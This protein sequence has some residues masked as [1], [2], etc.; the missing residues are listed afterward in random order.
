MLF[1]RVFDPTI[2]TG[3]EISSLIALIYDQQW[4]H[5]F[6]STDISYVSEVRDINNDIILTKNKLSLHATINGIK[7]SLIILLL[8]EGGVS[9][10]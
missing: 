9:Y 6:D 10:L 8:R 5:L 4:M 3:F 2:A 7:F 1:G